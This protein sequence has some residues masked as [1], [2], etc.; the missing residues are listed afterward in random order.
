MADDTINNFEP[1]QL[2]SGQWMM[3]RR[4]NDYST[5]PADRTWL[6]GGVTSISDW[7]SSPIP[8]AA[9]DAQAGRAGL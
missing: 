2:P 8:V 7:Q 6:V 9:N 4:G 5:D 3:S 1:K